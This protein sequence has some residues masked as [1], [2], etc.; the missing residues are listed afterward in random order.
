M[1]CRPLH[2]FKYGKKWTSKKAM[3]CIN[4]RNFVT[5]VD[6]NIDLKDVL[7]RLGYVPFLAT[8]NLDSAPLR[9][10]CLV[11]SC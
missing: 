5:L 11:G 7:A 1:V 2:K 9:N 6:K 4:M 8:V 3:K 10:A